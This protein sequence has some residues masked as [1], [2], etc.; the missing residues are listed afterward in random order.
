MAAACSTGGGTHTSSDTTATT[1]PH[2]STTTTGNVT[3]AQSSTTTSTAGVAACSQVTATAG[4]SQGAAGTIIGTITLTAVGSATC[5]TLGYPSLARFS[6]SGAPV[7]VTVV[8]GLTV[9][10]SGPAVQPPSPVTLTSSRQG[11][12]TYQY[13]DVP[14]GSETT[15]ASSATVSVTVPGGSS[16]SPPAPLTMAPCDNSTVEVSPIYAA[17]TTG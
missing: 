14:T 1:A 3:P 5:T 2:K 15:C 4:Q 6:A 13:S 8:H 11:E 16:G 9:N 12:F 10:L 7:P 17:P